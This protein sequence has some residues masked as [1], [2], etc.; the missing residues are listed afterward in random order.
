M[1][2]LKTLWIMYKNVNI[3]NKRNGKYMKKRIIVVVLIIA[4]IQSF[5]MCVFANT[6]DELKQ[7]KK[8]TEEKHTDIKE[9]L[10]IELDAICEL[11][12]EISEYEKE[13]G[14]LE[15]KIEELN[16]SIKNSEIEIEN[17]QKEHAEKE[18]LLEDRLVAI[19]M[20]GNTTYLDV[21]LSSEDI[22][23]LISNYYMVQQL[24]EA[25]NKLLE[26]IEEQEN[27]IQSTKQKM[28]NE[29]KEID[30]AK[31]EIEDKNNELKSKRVTRQEKADNL[32]AEEKSLKDKI[33]E[34][35]NSI[36]KMEE[37]L[38]K[39]F[40]NSNYESTYSGGQMEWPI[41]GEYYITSYVGW[42]WGRMHK[43]ID[44][45]ADEYTPVI[46]AEAGEVIIC[47]Y[48]TGGYGYYI[49]INHGNGYI[50]LYGHLNEQLVSVGQRVARGERIALSGN[51]GGSTGPHLHFEVRYLSS[52]RADAWNFFYNAEVK[53]PL[54][55]V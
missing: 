20:A 47:T 15:G 41:P 17:L 37:E 28:E 48:D 38:A 50:T 53:N 36:D 21:L 54:D 40:E 35:Q 2:C 24:A 22:T 3:Y 34:Y 49:A 1:E 55:F 51:T 31:R 26:T 12:A 30:T 18:K 14:Q 43:G 5:G 11:D 39:A 29:K 6:I 27:K 45:G 13:I 19:Y 52:G 46:A 9:E 10:S 32:S 42:R 8:E 16:A 33:E 7:Q 4:I 25:D 44:I 23:S